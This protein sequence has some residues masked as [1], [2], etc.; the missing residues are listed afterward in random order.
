MDV[1]VRQHR[2]VLRALVQCRTA[3]LGGHRDRRDGCAQPAFSYNSCPGS[4][5]SRS[6]STAA[7]NAWVVVRERELLPVGYVHV[8]FNDAGA[9]GT[10]RAGE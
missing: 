10:P 6:A 3:A 1:D 4:T 9:A 2:R 7:R 8:V 5:L